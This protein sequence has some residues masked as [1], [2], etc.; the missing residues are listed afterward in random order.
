MQK[1]EN[2]LDTKL[3][4]QKSAI[5]HG[6]LESS[7]ESLSNHNL[8]ESKSMKSVDAPIGWREG[9]YEEV[10]DYC[11]KDARLTYDLYKHAKESGVLKSRSFETGDIVEVEIEW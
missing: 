7:L 8:G 2:V 11:L 9:R 6:R 5:S 10:C 3:L 1:S 4:F